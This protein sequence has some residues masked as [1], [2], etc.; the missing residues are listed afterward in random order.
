MQCGIVHCTRGK[1]TIHVLWVWYME[2]QAVRTAGRRQ[3]GVWMCTQ[4]RMWKVNFMSMGTTLGKGHVECLICGDDV[5]TAGKYMHNAK[6]CIC[7]GIVQDRCISEFIGVLCECN[8]PKVLVNK[9]KKW[10]KIH[11]QAA[12]Q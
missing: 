6:Q 8:L 1:T 12:K 9:F 11:D 7:G 2:P 10:Q 4:C 5:K 3:L